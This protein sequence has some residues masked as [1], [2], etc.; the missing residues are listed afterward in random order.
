[1]HNQTVIEILIENQK[2]SDIGGMHRGLPSVNS[3]LV[4]SSTSA[5]FV[6]SSSSGSAGSSVYGY[7][8]AEHNMV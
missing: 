4:D 8:W 3:V 2:S 5:G 7:T 1:M 6:G